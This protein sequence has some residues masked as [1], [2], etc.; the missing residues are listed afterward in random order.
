MPLEL[1][2]ASAG[3]GLTAA[4]SLMARD[5]GGPSI[6]FQMPLC[7]MLDPRNSTPSHH[8]ITDNHVW[9]T[10]CNESAWKMYLGN[11]SITTVSPYAA[12][13][14]A[15]DFSNLPPTYTLVG[16]LDR[17]RDETLEYVTKLTQAGVPTEFTL[18]PGCFHCFD[19][20]L[21]N[22][23]ISKRASTRILEALLRHVFL[24][25]NLYCNRL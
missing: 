3:G 10:A 25:K 23:Q 9:N 12:P 4:N 21:P 24:I 7:P 2:L 11:E 13:I 6:L 15:T 17:F 18:Y 22:A 14:L 5:R 8:E 20:M 16:D 19:V 1:P